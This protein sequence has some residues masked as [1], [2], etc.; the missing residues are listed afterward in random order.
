MQ[1]AKLLDAS[2]CRSLNSNSFTGRIPPSIGNLSTLF[3]L[4]LADNQLEGPLPVSDGTNP[5]LDKLL[6]TKHL[7]VES[8]VVFLSLQVHFLY[9]ACT[10]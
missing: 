6:H 2:A 9:V 1:L 5:G 7:Y 3:W 4:D 8:F 10:L